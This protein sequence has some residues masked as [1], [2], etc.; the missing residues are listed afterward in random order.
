MILVPSLF[1]KGVLRRGGGGDL[2]VHLI[3]NDI[4]SRVCLTERSVNKLLSFQNLHGLHS[5]A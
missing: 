3:D 5:D 1:Q 4:F 2:R